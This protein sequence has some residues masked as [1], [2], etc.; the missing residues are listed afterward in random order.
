MINLNSSSIKDELQNNNLDFEHHPIVPALFDYRNYKNYINKL[1]NKNL[2]GFLNYEGFDVK[3]PGDIF[4]RIVEKKPVN[5]DIY[6]QLARFFTFKINSHIAVKEGKLDEA[7]AKL[8]LEWFDYLNEN[9]FFPYCLNFDDN[10]YNDLMNYC[11]SDARNYSLVLENDVDALA[12]LNDLAKTGNIVKFFPKFKEQFTNQYIMFERIS[13]KLGTKIS[14]ILYRDYYFRQNT[15]KKP[16]K[17]PPRAPKN[18]EDVYHLYPNPSSRTP[19]TKDWNLFTLLK[20]LKHIK[21]SIGSHKEFQ[22]HPLLNPSEVII[23]DFDPRK[24]QITFRENFNIPK[25]QTYMQSLL[26]LYKGFKH[27]SMFYSIITPLLKQY[28]PKKP[29]LIQCPC[30]YFLFNSSVKP[31]LKFF[32]VICPNCFCIFQFYRPILMIFK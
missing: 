16:L 21:N 5:K 13:L 11:L 31:T 8:E 22:Y 9:F 2:K 32:T 28:A 24:N 27:I 14:E 17:K 19:K 30:C 18:I 15:S 29:L 6:Y 10:F 3:R 20:N 23:E 26:F 7:Y 1:F 12:K 4:W 25:L